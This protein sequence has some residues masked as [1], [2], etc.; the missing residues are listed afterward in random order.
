MSSRGHIIAIDGPAGAGKSTVAR[1]VADALSYTLVDTGAMYRTAA[2]VAGRL[3]VSLDDGPSVAR[4]LTDLLASGKL[5]F[6]QKREGVRVVFD[7]ED[8]SDAIR[9][10]EIARG[11]SQVS[12]HPAVRD[13]LVALQ[14]EVGK[15]GAV[16]LEGRD[17]GTVVFP[18]APAKFFV[19]ARDEVRAHR[20]HAELALKGDPATFE[21]TLKEVRER[22]ERD[23]RRSIAPLRQASDAVLIDTSDI[24]AE[25]AALRVV[26]F[27]R[28]LPP[29]A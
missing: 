15:A 25:E 10:P 1:L 8:V 20:R 6:E 18:D 7:S 3:G 23:Q 14:R 29:P 27:V 24:T 19:T 17:I 28:E 2:L 13:V 26:V 21:S 11:A 4:T 16:V 9:S 5:S 22:D 12:Q